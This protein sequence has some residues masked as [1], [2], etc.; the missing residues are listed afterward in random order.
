MGDK[1]QKSFYPNGVL[2]SA[3]WGSFWG[4]MLGYPPPP[5]RRPPGDSVANLPTH[6]P[7]LPP[8]S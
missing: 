6:L 7:P 4:V 8:F 2:I 1:H 5:P 3:L